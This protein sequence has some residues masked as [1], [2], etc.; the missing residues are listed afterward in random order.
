MKCLRNYGY[1]ETKDNENYIEYRKNVDGQLYELNFWKDD[2]T[3]S[4]NH[5]RNI[6][7]ITIQ[8]LKVI[9]KKCEELGWL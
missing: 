5:F 6:G 8:E 2:K 1:I 4:K 3:F 9:N 7:Y